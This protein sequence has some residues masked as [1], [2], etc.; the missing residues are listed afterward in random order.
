VHLVGLSHISYCVVKG[1][2]YTICCQ[3][4]LNTDI[5]TTYC[6]HIT[7]DLFDTQRGW[8]T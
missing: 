2:V 5:L 6:I 7:F 8:R 1:N 4:Q 3:T